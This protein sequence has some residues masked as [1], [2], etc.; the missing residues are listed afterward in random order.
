MLPNTNSHTLIRH[1]QAFNLTE[2]TELDRGSCPRYLK[3]NNPV[4]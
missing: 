4:F 3:R 2:I 1:S